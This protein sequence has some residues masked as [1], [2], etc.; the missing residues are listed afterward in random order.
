MH[1]IA[2]SETDRA[3]GVE[4]PVAPRAPWRVRDLQVVAH[5]LLDVQFQDGTR[6]T[7]DLRPRLARQDLAGTVF[8]PLRDVAFF[9]QAAVH[10]GTIEWPGE[11][12]LAPD[13]MYDA[14]RAH[15]QWVLS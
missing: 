7:V 3:A 13:A 15:G 8:A 1:P 4:P 11:I 9:A 6:G 5:G 10:L 12:D 14:I 2:E